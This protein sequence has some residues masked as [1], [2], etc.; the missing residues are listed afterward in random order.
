MIQLSINTFLVEHKTQINEIPFCLQLTD[1]L[2]NVEIFFNN[3]HFPLK[4]PTETA[5][6]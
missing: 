1:F 3:L 5:V 6:Y 2:F 4:Y